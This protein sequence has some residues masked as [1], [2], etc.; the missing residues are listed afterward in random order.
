MYRSSTIIVHVFDNFMMKTQM[1]TCS[2][3]VPLFNIKLVYTRHQNIKLRVREP[4][5]M[6][7]ENLKPRKKLS[8]TTRHVSLPQMKVLFSRVWGF[9]Y[10]ISIEGYTF[11]IPCACMLT[12]ARAKTP[13]I[14]YLA[15]PCKINTMPYYTLC[16][17][18]IID[19]R[20]TKKSRTAM[21]AVTAGLR[22]VCTARVCV[23]VVECVCVCTVYVCV[24]V[25]VLVCVCAC[26]CVCAYVSVCAVF[27]CVRV[28]FLCLYLL[29]V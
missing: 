16:M 2:A 3:S 24:C 9:A 17:W 4:W 22:A 7:S 28:L 1:F 6:I 26:M 23:C 29:L 20:L 11:L 12:F 19:Q 13:P 10:A 14:L 15:L 27:V 8:P 25:C 18:F 21:P 5:L